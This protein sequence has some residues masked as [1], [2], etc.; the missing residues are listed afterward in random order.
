MQR[1][2]VELASFDYKA[3]E[4]RNLVVDRT[5]PVIEESTTF[6]LFGDPVL[7]YVREGFDPSPYPAAF[8][9]LRFPGKDSTSVSTAK[10]RSKHGTLPTSS[11]RMSGIQA[12]SVT[13]GNLHAEPA[14]RRFQAAQCRANFDH[15]EAW[16]AV[17]HLL[18]QAW[19]TVEGVGPFGDYSG[20]VAA[21]WKIGGT[22]FTSAI[23]NAGGAE[24]PYHTDSGNV[25]GSWSVMPVV[26]GGGGSGGHLVLPELGVA[27]P[28][29]S[30]DVVGFPGAERWHGVT[31]I[32]GER[33]SVVFYSKEKL[34]EAADTP[35]A[36]LAA[37]QI[38]RTEYEIE[39]L[40][41]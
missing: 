28:C 16:R 12:P 18:A 30:G 17:Q 10:T 4:A 25:R 37:G 1:V 41:V 40:E 9:R 20:S 27:L 7:I 34:K 14:R 26:R 6:Y 24:Y 22:P 23:V 38:R 36:E 2:D 19:P 13:F 5:Y 39:G 21:C 32:R 29:Y 33:W 3:S 35:E 15:R 8:R 31:P 11:Q